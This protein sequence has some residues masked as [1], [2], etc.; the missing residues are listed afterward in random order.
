MS[1]IIKWLAVAFG[2]ALGALLRYAISGLALRLLGATFPWGTLFANL[3]GCF[4]IGLFW[5]LSDRVAFP[6]RLHPFL[7]TGLLGAFTTFS[8]YSLESIH[9]LHDGEVW[10]GLANIGVSNGLGL[11]AVLL[12]F[13]CAHFLSSS[14][15]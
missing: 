9:L 14:P 8:T 6:P 7:F 10:R 5:A 1:P 3:L 11:L 13:G 12:G 4:F 2:G 15:R